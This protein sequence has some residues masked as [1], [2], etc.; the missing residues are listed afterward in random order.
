MYRKEEVREN[1]DYRISYDQGLRIPVLGYRYTLTEP[2]K[3][4]V[5]TSDSV[6]SDSN[7]SLCLASYEF[8]K[9]VSATEPRIVFGGLT[10]V[11][12]TYS[13]ALGSLPD[14]FAQSRTT[15]EKYFPEVFKEVSSK[16]E[17]ATL[18]LTK[19]GWKLQK[20]IKDPT[21]LIRVTH[22]TRNGEEE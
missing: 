14:E 20:M 10:A 18:L 17:D 5:G 22:A 15:M 4:F 9:V 2:Y 13:L 12:V 8:D 3:K 7:Q 21:E 6:F 11:S 1:Y 19:E 16:T